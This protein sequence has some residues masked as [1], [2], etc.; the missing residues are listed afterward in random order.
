[1]ELGLGAVEGPLTAPWWGLSLPEHPHS[2]PVISLSLALLHLPPSFLGPA[3]SPL[4]SLPPCPGPWHQVDRAIAACAELHD[5]KEVVL[6]NQR[7][8]EGVRQET[9]A[10]VRPRAAAFARALQLHSSG[11]SPAFVQTDFSWLLLLP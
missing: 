1:M 9:P 11:P 6:E 7:K 5:L 2:Q 3:P 4:L 8:L 10:E